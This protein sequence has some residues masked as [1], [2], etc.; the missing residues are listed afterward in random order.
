MTIVEL[1]EAQVKRI[2][3]EMA[4][5]EQEV[6]ALAE[7]VATGNVDLATKA[8]LRCKALTLRAEFRAKRD[9]YVALC[10]SLCREESGAA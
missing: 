5:I 3:R 2:Q 8:E 6:D 9:Q 4:A 10:L 7:A 1:Y